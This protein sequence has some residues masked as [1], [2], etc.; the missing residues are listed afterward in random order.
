MLTIAWSRII[1]FVTFRWNLQKYVIIVA[2][3]AGGAAV[4]VG[5]FMYGIAGLA[6]VAP[7]SQAARQAINGGVNWSTTVSGTTNDYLTANNIRVI[8][9]SGNFVNPATV[10][11]SQYSRSV[12][13][14]LRQ[15]PGPRNALGRIKFMF[16]NRFNVY[17]H[18]TPDRDD[19]ARRERE[20]SSGCIRV[21]KPF[22]LAELLLNDPV[23]WGARQIG[24]LVDSKRTRTVNLPEPVPV[25]LLYWTVAVGEDGTVSFKPDLYERDDALLKALDAAFRPGDWPPPAR[26]I[27][28][29]RGDAP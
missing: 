5:T 29:G 6:A 7:L 19:F 21:Q 3:A 23:K 1:I 13:Y 20:A 22:E 14:T 4:I 11:W 17:L 15:D 26:R 18:D 9:A 27:G 16:P 25:L 12:P 24:D 10:D 28:T 2:T 8:D